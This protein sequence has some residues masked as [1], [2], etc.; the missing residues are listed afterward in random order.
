MIKEFNI[1]NHDLI[2]INSFMKVVIYFLYRR[3]I[4]VYI[5]QSTNIYERVNNHI[6]G[7]KK[8][9]DSFSYFEC[10][11]SLLNEYE[12]FLICYYCPE[13]NETLHNGRA[14]NSAKNKIKQTKEKYINSLS[15]TDRMTML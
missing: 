11:R 6:K 13:Y 5:G 14:S 8:I 10:P 9:F 12:S 2:K 3:G 1:T 4:L 7:K 15:F